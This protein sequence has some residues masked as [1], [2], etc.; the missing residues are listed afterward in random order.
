[1]LA[2]CTFDEADCQH[3]KN[4]GCAALRGMCCP[5]TR[6]TLL[7]CCPG[8]KRQQR[9]SRRARRRPAGQESHHATVHLRRSSFKEDNVFKCDSV[10]TFKMDPFLTCQRHSAKPNL[11]AHG[12]DSACFSLDPYVRWSCYADRVPECAKAVDLLG[13]AFDGRCLPRGHPDYDS[14]PSYSGLIA[15]TRP[16]KGPRSLDGTVDE[17]LRHRQF[18]KHAF[19]WNPTSTVIAQNRWCEV[20]VPASDFRLGTCSKHGEPQTISILSYNVFWRKLYDEQQGNGY[21]QNTW[22]SWTKED[23]SAGKLIANGGPFDILAFQECGD[24][25][26]IV[27]DAGLRGRVGVRSGR[28][29]VAVAWNHFDWEWLADNHEPIAEDQRTSSD[30]SDPVREAVWVRLRHKKTRKTVFFLTHQGPPDAQ[31]PGGYCGPH[32]TA[33]NLMRV[34]AD[35]AHPGDNVIISGD[36]NAFRESTTIRALSQH[37][38]LLP[39]RAQVEHVLSNCAELKH[40]EI[41]G[42]G[43]SD[44]DAIKVE[45][46]IW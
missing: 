26:R 36:F 33:Y 41:L 25:R 22:G 38:T 20:G 7:H 39:T 11:P 40:H 28:H 3:P 43:G 37:L 19:R 6:G 35:A 23:R 44:H 31:E 9:R 16:A 8:A 17:T 27:E 24:V 13:N 46:D 5:T 1:M 12:Y 2:C 30:S 10:P 4:A 15:E 42:K 14:L 21:V 45:L 29:R 18:F 34:A 32:A